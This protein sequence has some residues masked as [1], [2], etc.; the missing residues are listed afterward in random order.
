[1]SIISE[2]LLI[3]QYSISKRPHSSHYTDKANGKLERR[4][5]RTAQRVN[6][7]LS[8]RVESLSSYNKQ[9]VRTL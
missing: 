9:A 1:M 3:N 4:H 5:L 7:W 2:T 8:N 6:E